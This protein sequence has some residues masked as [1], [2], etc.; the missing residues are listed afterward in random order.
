MWVQT[1]TTP[2]V[3][4]DADLEV[5]KI[6]IDQEFR[7][8]IELEDIGEKAREGRSTGFSPQDIPLEQM[9]FTTP[10]KGQVSAGFMPDTPAGVIL[11][12]VGVI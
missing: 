12:A 1:Y 9:Y 2:A 10:V 5:E 7:E 11:V 3:S 4:E 8:E 6:D